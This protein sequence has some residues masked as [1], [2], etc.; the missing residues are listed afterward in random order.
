MGGRC[1]RLRAHSLIGSPWQAHPKKIPD[2]VEAPRWSQML[3]NGTGWEPCSR[4]WAVRR[5]EAQER[6]PGSRGSTCLR[7]QP[8]FPRCTHAGLLRLSFQPPCWGVTV[9]S[10]Q[11]TQRHPEGAPPLN[12]QSALRHVCF[13]SLNSWFLLIDLGRHLHSSHLVLIECRFLK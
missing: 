8:S 13:P 6:V 1:L 11:G 7:G 2:G 9:F 10:L 3:M 12:A 5:L 4:G